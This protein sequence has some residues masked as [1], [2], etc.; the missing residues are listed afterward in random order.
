VPAT[1]PRRTNPVTRSRSARG[2][3]RRRSGQ[4]ASICRPHDVARAHAEG[5]VYDPTLV[6]S[7]RWSCL[8]SRPSC[9]PR[10]AG[11]RR[12]QRSRVRAN[13][14]WV[15]TWPGSFSA[16]PPVVH[17]RQEAPCFYVERD[18]GGSD[19]HRKENCPKRHVSRHARPRGTFLSNGWISCRGSAWHSGFSAA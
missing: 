2:R 12:H 10:R 4:R 8:P 3:P 17:E 6:V 9:S 16:E 18:V 14:S 19:W 15:R 11:S 7:Y 5:K 1:L 13:W